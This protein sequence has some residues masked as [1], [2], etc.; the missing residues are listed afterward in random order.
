MVD[1]VS[2]EYSFEN[3]CRSM[4]G[5]DPMEVLDTASAEITY[6]HRNHKE[7]TRE[8]NF[9]KG[10]RGRAYCDDLQRLISLF[11]GTVPEPSPSKFLAALMPLAIDVLKRCEIVGLRQVVS[12]WR[13]RERLEK[14]PTPVIDFLA[15]V[16]S[17]Q[18][19]ESGDIRGPLG[20]LS[21]LIESPPTAKRFAERV[22]IVFDGYN[23]TPQELFE[24]ASVRDFV[25]QLDQQFPYWLFFLSK[26]CLGLQ[27]LFLCLLPEPVIRDESEELYRQ[28]LGELL[29]HR[30]FPAMNHICAFAGYSEQERNALTDRV[31]AYVKDGRIPPADQLNK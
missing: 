29:L 15:V 20:V 31:E 14:T 1:L 24:M 30:W 13:E 16:I 10:S 21:R 27:C 7:R 25:R 3:F 19:V 28:R 23:D 17:R 2:P 9:R 5:K 12:M 26:R 18:E 4:V 6:A 8:W 11:M 22:D